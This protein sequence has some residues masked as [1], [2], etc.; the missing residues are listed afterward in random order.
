MTT[1]PVACSVADCDGIVRVPKSL[2]DDHDTL[3]GL[4][5]PRGH[6][7]DAEKGRCPRCGSDAS[8]ATF[9][10]EQAWF[11]DRPPSDQPVFKPARC[12]NPE[13]DWEGPKG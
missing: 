8:A 11:G 13:C 1:V 5:C 3:V 4:K 7:F 2:Y 6:R 9:K 10:P 12:T